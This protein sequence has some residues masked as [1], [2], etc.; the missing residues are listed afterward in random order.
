[1]GL[2]GAKSSH[3]MRQWDSSADRALA[4][5]RRSSERLCALSRAFGE[6]N[7]A[8]YEGLSMSSL[9]WT[10]ASIGSSVIIE[11]ELCTSEARSPSA[12]VSSWHRTV[13]GATGNRS[14]SEGSGARRESITRSRSD[15]TGGSGLS[16]MHSL[17]R[18]I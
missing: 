7:R 9:Y 15:L 3:L 5:I 16:S 12:V 18:N 17:W 11:A 10:L 4:A 6:R 2:C 8:S 14:C 1:M 13:L